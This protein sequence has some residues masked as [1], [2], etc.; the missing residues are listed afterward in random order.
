[1]SEPDTTSLPNKNWPQGF[2]KRHPGFDSSSSQG[3]TIG[4]GHSHAIYDEVVEWFDVI[5]ELLND[6][7]IAQENI[8][9]MAET[10]FILSMLGLLS[11]VVS[12]NCT[13]T[14]RPA[15]VQRMSLTSKNSFPADDRIL[16]PLAI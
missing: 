14:A 3:K 13:Q 2:Y 4:N 9:N 11:G 12:D 7:D 8:Y 15:C 16:D 1:M 5:E 10:N 6:A